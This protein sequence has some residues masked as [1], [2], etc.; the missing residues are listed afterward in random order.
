MDATTMPR[1]P[2]SSLFSGSSVYPIHFLARVQRTRLS[3]DRWIPTIDVADRNEGDDT[4]NR[5]IN[6]HCKPRARCLT[7]KPRQG[8]RQS[9]KN[10]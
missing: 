10:Q 2:F 4:V 8:A 5:R 7:T 9:V 1:K 3:A 6:A